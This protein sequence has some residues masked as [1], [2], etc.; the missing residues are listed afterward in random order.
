MTRVM[1]LCKFFLRVMW[2]ISRFFV[3]VYALRFILGFAAPHFV[4]AFP[5][6]IFF[7]L[8]VI[9]LLLRMWSW[10]FQFCDILNISWTHIIVLCVISPCWIRNVWRQCGWTC[11]FHLQWDWPKYTCM[12]PILSSHFILLVLIQSGWRWSRHV[13]FYTSD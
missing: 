4:I 2:I 5:R 13:L 11:C 12:L 10:T 7:G 9:V 3:A 1:R 6:M 8:D